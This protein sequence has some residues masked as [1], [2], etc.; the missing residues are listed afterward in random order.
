[1]RNEELQSVKEDINILYTIKARTANWISH[2]MHRNCLIKD[3]IAGNIEEMVDVMGRRGRGR[4]QL[5]DDRK[6]TRV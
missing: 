5:L 4:E 6:E 2:I 3:D 1:V